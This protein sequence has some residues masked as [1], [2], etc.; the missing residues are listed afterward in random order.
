MGLTADDL[1]AVLAL[2]ILV[3]IVLTFD[4]WWRRRK[5]RKAP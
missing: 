1:K 3:T 5:E 2:L 4:I